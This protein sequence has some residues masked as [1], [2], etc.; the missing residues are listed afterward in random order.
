MFVN[1]GLKTQFER[2]L[3]TVKECVDICRQKPLKIMA[4][5]K[6]VSKSDFTEYFIICGFQTRKALSLDAEKQ[7]DSTL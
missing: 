7:R 2:P 4:C 1:Q 3:P 6:T 5:K